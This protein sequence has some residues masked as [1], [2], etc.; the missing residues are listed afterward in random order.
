MLDWELPQSQNFEQYRFPSPC[1]GIGVLDI[2]DPDIP[3]NTAYSCE[4]GFHP[5]AGELG[6]WTIV[7]NSSQIEEFKFPSPCG[8]IGVLDSNPL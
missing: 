6:C 3:I 5:L 8:G 1:G 4:Q 2:E 7:L